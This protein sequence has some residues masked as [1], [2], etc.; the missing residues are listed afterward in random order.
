MKQFL[1][2]LSI[3]G[4]VAN[5]GLAQ[6]GNPSSIRVNITGLMEGAYSIG[7]S[8]RPITNSRRPR[9]LLNTAVANDLNED[10]KRDRQNANSSAASSGSGSASS[11]AGTPS[12]SPA[13]SSRSSPSSPSSLTSS[14]MNQSLDESHHHTQGSSG[15]SAKDF[16]KDL[17]GDFQMATASDE[18]IYHYLS[19]LGDRVK[20]YLQSAAENALPVL[21]VQQLMNNMQQALQEE[22]RRRQNDALEQRIAEAFGALQPE[23]VSEIQRAIN[24]SPDPPKPPIDTSAPLDDQR[25]QAVDNDDYNH[26]TNL[27]MQGTSGN[28]RRVR[29][30]YAEAMSA[31]ANVAGNE[32]ATPEQRAAARQFAQNLAGM[33]NS[34]GGRIG[35]DPLFTDSCNVLA[36]TCDNIAHWKDPPW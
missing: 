36:A 15:M 29:D 33:F 8:V 27:A 30:H 2:A 11:P 31:A 14:L 28:F 34:L 26:L 3:T 16:E 13:S 23:T 32:N 19:S 9:P 5:T 20:P 18:D 4:F 22:A 35:D 25:R 21:E 24:E 1:L 10:Q 6:E 7:A 12:S 17:M